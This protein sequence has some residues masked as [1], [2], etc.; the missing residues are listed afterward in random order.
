MTRQENEQ[1]V[2]DFFEEAKPKTVRESGA[3]PAV[4]V[5]K[6]KEPRV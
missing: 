1:F 2:R 6:Y 3:T 5:E 4:S